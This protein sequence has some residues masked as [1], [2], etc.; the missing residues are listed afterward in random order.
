MSTATATLFTGVKHD[1]KLNQAV[2]ITSTT[3]KCEFGLLVHADSGNT[4]YVFVGGNTVTA[5]SGLS[6]DGYPISP[7]KEVNFAVRSP[8]TLYIV[9]PVSGQ[10]AWFT[11]N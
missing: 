8:D 10:R 7:G 3:R 5:G 6:T 1:L 11:V 2:Q 9:S 4:N